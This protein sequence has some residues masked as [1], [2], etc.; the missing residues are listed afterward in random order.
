VFQDDLPS[1]SISRLRASGVIARETTE[2]VVK[3]G[4]VEQ[5]VG[6]M[7]RRF[8]NGGGWS[9]F[10]CPSCGWKVRMLRLLDGAVVCTRCCARRGAGFRVWLMSP[11]Q[12]AERLSLKLRSMLETETSLR[13]K[14]VLW[15]KLE[16][17]KRLEA[18]LKRC[19][20]IVSQHQL[21]GMK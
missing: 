9:R 2:F 10:V 18:A 5:M 6:V 3:L 20:Y 17:R 12:R 16:R 19:E 7:E 1:I 4:D 8:P 13:L 21:R 11:R 14:P 15:G